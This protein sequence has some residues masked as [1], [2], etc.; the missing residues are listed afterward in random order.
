MELFL[1]ENVLSDH[2]S[3]LIILTGLHA[4]PVA[5]AGETLQC[6]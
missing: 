1:G 3:A 5:R 6:P 4:K 2:G